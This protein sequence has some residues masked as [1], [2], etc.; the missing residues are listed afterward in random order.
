MVRRVGLRLTI[1]R[2]RAAESIGFSSKSTPT[3]ESVFIIY[4]LTR[5]LLGYFAIRDPRLA[6]GGR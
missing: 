3:P 2:I 1:R 4:I 5:Q 6:G